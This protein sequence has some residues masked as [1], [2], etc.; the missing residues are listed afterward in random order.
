MPRLSGEKFGNSGE[1]AI[2]V[3]CTQSSIAN[4][5]GYESL[6]LENGVCAAGDVMTLSYKYPVQ[7][8][9]L[10]EKKSFQERQRVDLLQLLKQDA[11]EFLLGNTHVNSESLPSHITNVRILSAKVLPSGTMFHAERSCTQRGYHYLLPVK[12][13]SGGKEIEKWWISNNKDESS[14]KTKTK[15][16]TKSG[17]KGEQRLGVPAPEELRTLKTILRSFESQNKQTN[18]KISDFDVNEKRF[19]CLSTKQ[20]KAWHNFADSTIRGTA[21]S[22]SNKPVWR[23][24]DRCRIIKFFSFDD[25][26]YITSDGK[27]TNNKIV[28]AVIEFRGDDF[29][30]QQVRK[31]IGT[32]VAMANGWLPSNFEEIAISPDIF[33]ET[34]LAPQN[35]MYQIR[36]KFHFDEL[37]NYGK[38]IFNNEI[39]ADFEVQLTTELHGRMIERILYQAE[40]DNM[41]LETLEKKLPLASV[42]S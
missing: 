17:I 18:N 26:N 37:S 4:L 23:S 27:Y 29:I 13:I 36:P 1:E 40:S 31:I 14:G 15:S 9:L 22:P 11:I 33:I 21:V 16:K 5:R 41:W 30:Q 34:P 28:M 39:D 7:Q 6:S 35:H 19:G 24:L 12:W 2:V 42:H 3:K 10:D 38:S 20:L 8:T 25:E 32:A